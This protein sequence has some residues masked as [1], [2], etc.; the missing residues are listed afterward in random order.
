MAQVLQGCSAPF[1]AL[2][3]TSALSSFAISCLGLFPA[4]QNRTLRALRRCVADLRSRTFGDTL[5]CSPAHTQR[6]PVAPRFQRAPRRQGDDSLPAGCERHWFSVENLQLGANLVNLQPQGCSQLL[7]QT[8][9]FALL[10][11]SRA[12]NT[13]GAHH[14]WRADLFS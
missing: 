8:P 1:H 4:R 6:R 2:I 14:M 9:Q 13:S 3:L 7:S 12:A 11:G 10:I 5:T